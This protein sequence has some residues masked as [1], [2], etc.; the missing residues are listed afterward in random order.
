MNRRE[1]RAAGKTPAPSKAAQSGPVALYEA[2]MAHLRAGRMLDAQ[3]W[4]GLSLAARARRQPWYPTTRLFRQDARRSYAE[5]VARVRGELS[6]M[7]AA[8]G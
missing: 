4:P 8:R 1:C 2:G 5:V 6:A 3:V 7:I